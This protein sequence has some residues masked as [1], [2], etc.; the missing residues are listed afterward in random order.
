MDGHKVLIISTGEWLS[1]C[2]WNAFMTKEMNLEK[3]PWL[4]SDEE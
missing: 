2:S 4:S 1:W 3:E